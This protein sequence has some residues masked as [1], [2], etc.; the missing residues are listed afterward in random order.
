M[1]VTGKYEN[2]DDLN[3]I[4]E[5]IINKYNNKLIS[6]HFWIEDMKDSDIHDTLI[7]VK[8]SDDIYN[9]IRAKFP[10]HKIKNVNEC[11][12]I[13]YAV[14]PKDASGSDRSLVDCHYDTPFGFLPNFNI[15]F[16]RVLLACNEN[17]DVTTKFPNDNIEVK[18][19]TGDFH[20][21]DYNKD[22]H[23]VE[24]EIPKNKNRILL[25]LHYILVPNE[26]EDDTL[27]EKCVRY[28]NVN[29]TYF[30]RNF[31]RMSS[32]PQNIF[33]YIAGTLVNISRFLYN[34]ILI[35]IIIII[36]IVFLFRNSKSSQEKK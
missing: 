2:V 34:N 6:K 30:S 27:S 12:E 17:S 20:G 29:W 21:L 24:G 15:I 14:S 4:T 18:M 22:Y 26:Y 25:K 8:Y 23:C 1:I 7:K 28:I 35:L 13:Y 10:N 11:D 33:E 32:N 19:T 31:M 3:S 36:F 16:Y 9:V 5:Y